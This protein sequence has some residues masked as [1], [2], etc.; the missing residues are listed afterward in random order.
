MSILNNSNHKSNFILLLLIFFFSYLSKTQAEITVTN[1]EAFLQPVSGLTTEQMQHFYQGRRLFRQVWIA[2]PAINEEDTE[3]DGLGPVYNRLSCLACHLKNG[4]GQPPTTP[5]EEM[6]SMLVRL[7]VPGQTI[8]GGPKPHPAYGDQLNEHGISQVP[9]EGRAYITYQEITETLGDGEIVKLR[10]P[11][12]RF[13]DLH[14]GELGKA[15]LT[16]PRVAPPVFGL[17]LLAAISDITIQTLADPKDKNQDGISGRVN[18]VWDTNK[19]QTVLGRFGWKANQP[20]LAQ[21]IAGAFVGDLGIT[22]T[23]FPVENCTEVQTACIQAISDDS[24]E[25]SSQQLEDIVFYHLALAVPERRLVNDPQVKTGEQIFTQIGCALCHQPTLTTG[26]FP[27]L[28]ALANQTI[29]PYTDLLLH[30]MGK[31]L[32]D[33]RPDYEANGQEWRTPPLWGIGLI[34]TVNGHT[35]LLHDG[36]AR[37]LLEAILWHGGEAQHSK[38]AVLQLSQSERIALIQFL[39]SL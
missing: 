25:L 5:Q 20:T 35:T 19:Q 22:S 2:S 24:P 27:Q 33:G 4:R 8:Q 10:Q 29:H 28:S 17:G 12:L 9:G 13:T 26:D 16:S 21:Q 6:R 1:S 38:D 37:H 7:S 23:L 14:F 32:A 34:E 30:D 39:Q 31:Q 36:R 15:T 11:Q 18:K 3:I